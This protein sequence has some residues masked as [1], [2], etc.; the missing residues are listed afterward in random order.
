MFAAALS[1]H[2]ETGN[3]GHTKQPDASRRV[4]AS[5]RVLRAI[6]CSYK[7]PQA[8]PKDHQVPLVGPRFIPWRPLYSVRSQVRLRSWNL[9]LSARSQQSSTCSHPFFTDLP[10]PCW[11]YWRSPDCWWLTF[12]SHLHLAARIGASD[13]GHE[14]VGGMLNAQKCHLVNNKRSKQNNRSIAVICKQSRRLQP[15]AV[16]KCLFARE[17]VACGMTLTS[18]WIQWLERLERTDCS[19]SNRQYEMHSS[20][21]HQ[22]TIPQHEANK[23]ARPHTDKAIR[24][25][26]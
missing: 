18:L 17:Q 25:C 20:R 6:L 7:Q 24:L 5:T 22:C 11:R 1:R 9:S 12:S 4:D 3:T 13:I 14:G 26:K 16:Q 10:P 19:V 23:S 15:L 21:K 8:G 2:G